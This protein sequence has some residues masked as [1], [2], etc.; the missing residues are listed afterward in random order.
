MATFVLT[1][2]WASREP[3]IDSSRCVRHHQLSVSGRRE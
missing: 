1:A 3:A 2:D